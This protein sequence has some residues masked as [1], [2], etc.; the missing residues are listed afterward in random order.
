[1]SMLIEAS[2]WFNYRFPWHQLKP[3]LAKRVSR[4]LDNSGG[5][6]IYEHVQGNLR[7]RL[8]LAVNFERHIYLNASN[9]G[10][11]S[12]FRKLLRPGDVVVDG[13]A[14][15]GFLSLVAWQCVGPRGKVYAFEPQP[16]AL[17]LLGEN[18]RLN[19]ADNIVVV[20]KALWYEPGVAT[21]YEFVGGGHDLPS[22]GRRSDKQVGQEFEVETVRMDDVVH[23][24][25]RLYKLDIEGAEWPAMR[26]SQKILFADPPPHVLIE[27][28]PRTCEAFGHYPLD[29]LDWFLDHA[30]D[31]HL[32]LVRRRRRVRVD[33]KDLARLFEAKPDKSHNVWFKPV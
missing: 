24:P 11:L 18:I 33:R 1:M 15:L 12:M 31:R 3:S 22:L 8:D 13:G 20:P 23:E 7:M 10:I 9:M 16:A 14:N 28:T 19:Q 26:G 6:M 17:K 21:L 25:V 30:P 29:V 4:R 27:L 2:R 5:P 32:Y